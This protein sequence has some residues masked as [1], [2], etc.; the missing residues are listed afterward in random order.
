MKFANV[1]V[2]RL[3]AQPSLA[4]K[5]PGCG[6]AV[7]AKCG[8]VRI[9][10]WAHRGNRICAYWWEPETEWH[11]GWKNQYP[12]SWQEVHHTAADGEKHI[13]DVKTEFGVVLEF[14]HSYLKPDERRSREA[15]YQKMVWVVNGRRRP[16][17]AERL[18]AAFRSAAFVSRQPP[19]VS[20]STDDGGLLRDWG[21]STVPVYFDFGES[22]LWRMNPHKPNGRAHLLG[23]T[24]ASFIEAHR[25]GLVSEESWTENIERAVAEHAVLLRRASQAQPLP[26]FQRYM[27]TRGQGRL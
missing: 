7:I 11:R 17:D 24:K 4:G 19:L 8:E 16:R 1:G 15:V 18:N 20:V 5:C 6:A 22:H 23:V 26:G 25:G 10:H 13:A 2:E 14:Q 12:E 21:A 27:A 9:H 3:E